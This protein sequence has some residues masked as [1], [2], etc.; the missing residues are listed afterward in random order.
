MATAPGS[1]AMNALADTLSD[2]IDELIRAGK[3][4][5][6]LSTTGSHG[7]LV[8]LAGRVESLEAAIRELARA[9][10]DFP[11]RT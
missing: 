2:R 1:D 4:Q 11:E 6:L 10:E 9:V 7:A 8:E 3:A 5:P